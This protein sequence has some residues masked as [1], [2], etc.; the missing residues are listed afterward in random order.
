[1]RGGG[2]CQGTAVDVH[3]MAIDVRTRDKGVVSEIGGLIHARFGRS[4]PA[5]SIA[6]IID[7]Q[8]GGMGWP[9]IADCWPDGADRLAVPIKPKK[10]GGGRRGA[11]K[12]RQSRSEERRVGKECR[13]RWSPN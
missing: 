3:A 1:M 11:A 4:A 5:C 13:S 10:G 9:E 7:D 6:R 8:Q 12:G 2:A